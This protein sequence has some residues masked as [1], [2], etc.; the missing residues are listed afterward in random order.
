MGG[1][2][3]E[4]AHP[5][6]R[7][8]ADGVVA[9]HFRSGIAV[10]TFELAAGRCARANDG[11]VSIAALVVGAAATTTDLGTVATAGIAGAAAGAISMA[12]GEYVS[13]STQR[14]TEKALVRLKRR[15]LEKMPDAKRRSLV[16]LLEE[17]GLSPATSR[18]VADELTARDALAAHLRLELGLDPAAIVNPWAAAVSSA[19][20]FTLGALLPLVAILVPPAS[21]VP[22]PHRVRRRAGR[23]RS[24]RRGQRPSRGRAEGACGDPPCRRWRTRH[25]GYLRDRRAVER[26][27]GLEDKKGCRTPRDDMRHRWRHCAHG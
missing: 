27:G 22:D 17:R 9:Q 7:A 24:H 6:S 10:A 18:Q 23:P 5:P 1:C 14:D 12:P 8:S 20:A 16:G 21:S 15:E 11:V 26:H 4:P 13:V 2:V 25:A 19:I 3:A